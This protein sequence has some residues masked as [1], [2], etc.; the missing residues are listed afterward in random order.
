[1]N[2][3]NIKM[4]IEYKGTRYS[5]WQ[6]QTNAPT[7][8][9]EIE[10]V[11]YKVTGQKISVNGS[12][13]T[14][15]GVHACG[16]CINFRADISIPVERLPF[17]LNAHLPKDIA[18][19]D[20]QLAHI[21]FHSRYHAKGKKYVYNIYN[22]R[23]PSPIHMDYCWHVAKKLDVQRM[24]EAAQY[25]IGSHDFGAFKSTGASNPSD[26]RTVYTIEFIENDD[27][28]SMEISGKSFLYNM[29]R[30]IMGTLVDVGLGKKNP[31]EI[32]DIILSKDRKNAG[33]TAP[34]NGLMLKEVYY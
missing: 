9:G 34:A 1:M 32:K 11:L 23:F 7:V 30:I 5:G 31:E 18:V 17:A 26:V 2:V 14:D 16:K 25:I 3:K 27:M 12:S 13:R 24:R 20:A 19:I 4:I 28:I 29:V 10:K 6:R 21:D 22:R 33:K 15:A 8:Q